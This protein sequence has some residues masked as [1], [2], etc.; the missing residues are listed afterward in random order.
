M[1]P[2]YLVTLCIVMESG[3]KAEDAVSNRAGRRE[4]DKRLDRIATY[5]DKTSP[6]NLNLNG[7]FVPKRLHRE[8]S[9]REESSEAMHCS[10]NDVQLFGI[11]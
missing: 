2:V 3:C 11:P 4:M 5:R 8:Y 9:L 7:R 6:K 10:K 1:Q